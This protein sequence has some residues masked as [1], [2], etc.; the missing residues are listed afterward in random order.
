M[1]F[2]H[3]ALNVPDVRA[4]AAWYIQHVGFAAA[5]VRT[6]PPY[7][8]FLADDSGR[9]V[10]ELYSNPAAPCLDFRSSDPLVFHFAVVSRDAA[11]DADR[12]QQAGATVAR[13]ETLGDGSRLIMLRDPWGVC[14]QLCQRTTPMP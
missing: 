7:T 6:E 4:Q 13:D 12:L 2:E 14:L 5:R 8:H 10:F 3:F 11:A 9:V 1:R